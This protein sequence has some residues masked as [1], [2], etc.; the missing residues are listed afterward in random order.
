MRQRSHP[1]YPVTFYYAF[2]QV[3]AEKGQ[4]QR[5]T[6]ILR[7]STGWEIMLQGLL[8]AGFQ[9]TGTWPVRTERATG[10]KVAI[11]A[12]ASSIV[13]VCRPRPADAPIATRR[14]FL[15]AL[16]RELPRELRVLMS[17]RVAPVDL[18]QAAIGP[19]MAVFSRYSKALEAEGSAMTVR[20]ALQEINYVI[21]DFLAQQE[22]D[23]DVESQ[24][25]VVWFQQYGAQ[26]GP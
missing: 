19:G 24:F 21:E 26:E 6:F 23:L 14:E 20:T 18:A 17:G 16:H 22:G 4:D 25:C 9:V 10:L 5:R 3:E 11:N 1:N 2:K 7:V 13:L 12:L 8:A 15:A